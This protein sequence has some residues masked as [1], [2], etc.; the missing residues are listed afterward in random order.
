MRS[1]LACNR[2][3]SVQSP[4]KLKKEA[5]QVWTLKFQDEDK[6]HGA[7][8]IGEDGNDR[9]LARQEIEFTDFPLQE[10]LKLFLENGV[11]MLPS[12]Y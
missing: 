1:L 7:L 9:E 2:H 6:D 8:L 12:E 4:K 3:I 5:F 11:L 10:G